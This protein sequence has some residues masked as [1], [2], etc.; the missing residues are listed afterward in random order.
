SQSSF[1]LCSLLPSR[2]LTIF[3]GNG[4]VNAIDG[5]D[6]PA[7]LCNEIILAVRGR[8]HIAVVPTQRPEQLTGTRQGLRGVVDSIGPVI[9]SRTDHDVVPTGRDADPTS[10]NPTDV[11][12]A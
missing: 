9:P 10:T 7:F 4:N 8:N 6:I 11:N 1:L 3:S 5:P 12:A 2:I